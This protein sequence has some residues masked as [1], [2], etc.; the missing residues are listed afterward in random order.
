MR[1][2]H[3][4][5][6]PYVPL[7][8]IAIGPPPVKRGGPECF[9]WGLG[10]QAHELGDDEAA[11]GADDVAEEGHEDAHGDQGGGAGT[12]STGTVAVMPMFAREATAQLNKLIY[13]KFPGF[14]HRKVK[15]PRDFNYIGSNSPLWFIII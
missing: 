5:W 12:A 9:L 6:P 2:I 13:H 3:I 8:N 11:A 15:N 14:V 4:C 10:N 7:R 1:C